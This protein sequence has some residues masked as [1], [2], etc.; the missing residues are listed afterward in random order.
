MQDC[1]NQATKR[2]IAKL[3]NELDLK[4]TNLEFKIII[5]DQHLESI[6]IFKSNTQIPTSVL[7][8]IKL[9]EAYLLGKRYN[10]ASALFDVAR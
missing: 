1:S 2:N 3:M 7:E 8:A 4:K 5:V 10:L 6:R 9:G